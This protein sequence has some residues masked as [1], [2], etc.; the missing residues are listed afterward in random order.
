M[1]KSRSN[2]KPLRI[3]KLKGIRKRN[4]G[5]WV[6]E[7]RIPNSRTKI[8]LGSYETAEQAAR[9][10]DFA[11]YVLKGPNATFNFIKS[12]TEI[13]PVSSL[14]QQEIQAAA[15]NFALRKFPEVPHINTAEGGE[16]LGHVSEVESPFAEEVPG[17]NEMVFWDSVLNGDC[18]DS[19][20]VEMADLSFPSPV[21]QH[22]GIILDQVEWWEFSRTA[23]TL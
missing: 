14:S 7:V 13:S 18:S 4:W 16:I 5:K 11:L 19:D 3:P 1:G 15:A 21:Q 22:G 10:Y 9:A 20:V 12:P 23:S 17:E 8:W 2:P 6:S